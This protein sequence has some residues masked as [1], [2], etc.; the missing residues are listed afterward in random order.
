MAASQGF[1]GD[2]L[3]TI[4]G[5]RAF[6]MSLSQNADRADDLVQETLVKAWD[7][8]SSFQPGTNLKAWL[9]TILRNEFYSQMRK[10]GREVQDS[11]GL[12]TARLA[13]H[14]SQP[15]RLDLDDFRK[16][17]EQLPEDQREAIILIGASGF[18]YEE[19]AEI[20]GCAVGT[21]K[22]RVSRAR[23]R[24]QEILDISGEADYGPDAIAAQVM[25]STVS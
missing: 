15:G 17:L 9:F 24:L 6:A 7:K 4:P 5:L 16:A 3:A 11:D 14:P 8:Q 21:I 12:L 2:L 22:S 19:A 13:V 18:S 10:R 25:G 23:N 20:C 1:K